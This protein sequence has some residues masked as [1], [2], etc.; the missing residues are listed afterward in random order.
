[1]A[2]SVAQ[3]EVARLRPS[4]E[5]A[6]RVAQEVRVTTERTPQ[7]RVAQMVVTVEPAVSVATS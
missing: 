1:M 2:V 4:V 6:A 5:P 7:A 3:V